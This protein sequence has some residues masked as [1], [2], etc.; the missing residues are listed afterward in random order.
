MGYCRFEDITNIVS[1]RELINLTNDK[2]SADS[3]AD[4]TR[5]EA[6]SKDTDSLING[7][8]RGRY[9]L[10]FSSVPAVIRQIAVD[11]CAYRLYSRRSQ[12]IPEHIVN[13][14][15]SAIS[16]LKDIQKGDLLLES[17]SEN[18][19]SEITPPKSG[20]R[21][22]K[23]KKDRIFNDRVMKAFRLS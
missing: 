14:Y 17:Y 4:K 20:F 6:V 23:T 11:I 21:C 9:K 15:N 10:P 2:P 22:S 1:E 13:N 18:E 5:F 8:L 16:R 19:E 12:K 7:Y 3:V